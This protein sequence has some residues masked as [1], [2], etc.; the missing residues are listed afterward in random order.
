MEALALGKTCVVSDIGAV[1]PLVI[2]GS[3]GYTFPL[4]DAD[5]LGEVVRRIITEEMYLN[6]DHL[7]AF[8]LERFDVATCGELMLARVRG[9]WGE[10]PKGADT[11]D[12][13]A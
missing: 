12:G 6:P 3:T 13:T 4:G 7:L 10:R 2:D 1:R 8:M 11:G 9:V 5:A